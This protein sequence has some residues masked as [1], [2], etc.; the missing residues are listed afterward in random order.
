MDKYFHKLIGIDHWFDLNE[1][2]DESIEMINGIP[3]RTT[4]LVSHSY[5]L[6]MTLNILYQILIWSIISLPIITSIVFSVQYNNIDIFLSNLYNLMNSVLFIAVVIYFYTDHYNDYL[7]KT[8]YKKYLWKISVI[9]LTISMIYALVMVLILLLTDHKIN[10]YSELRLLETVGMTEYVFIVIC[11]LLEKFIS[12]GVYIA[13]INIFVCSLYSHIYKINDFVRDYLI[14]V[15]DDGYETRTIVKELIKLRKSYSLTVSSLSPI[16]TVLTI[17]GVIAGYFIIKIE[18]EKRILN[19][20]SQY[21]SGV[22][23]IIL[24]IIYFIAVFKMNETL[25]QLQENHY[26]VNV[27]NVYLPSENDTQLF[28][29]QKLLRTQPSE[30]LIGAHAPKNE[31]LLTMTQISARHSFLFEWSFLNT[32]ICRPWDK[33]SFMGLEIDNSSIILKALGL[34]FAL[35]FGFELISL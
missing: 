13:T 30:R 10:I 15:S 17:I 20:I 1:K 29:D 12:F 18:T 9:E 2:Y 4:H 35:V 6:Q 24:E 21:I 5:A 14:D 34:I 11:M 16:F 7:M 31:M 28:S 3:V 25:N 27:L 23:F 8:F 33:F 22:I 32:E 26:S 19:G